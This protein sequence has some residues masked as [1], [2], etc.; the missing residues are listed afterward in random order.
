MQMLSYAN[1]EEI[2][3]ET[4]NQYLGNECRSFKPI[5][6]QGLITDYLGLSL[7]YKKLSKNGTVLGVTTF[8]E[9]NIEV[10]DDDV[11]SFECFPGNT[12]I[13]EKSL[14]N[15][16]MLGRKNFTISHE[17]AHQLLERL[18]PDVNVEICENVKMREYRTLQTNDDWK[19]WQADALASALLMPADLV[20]YAMSVFCGK[21]YIEKL[22]PVV[23]R[24]IFSQFSAMS[25]FLQV[26]KTA[27]A[28]RMKRL[29]LLGV[30][31]FDKTNKFMDVFVGV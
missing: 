9:V 7:E 27:L 15:D 14:K 21:T 24:D 31:D 1:I 25:A 4:L 26:S 10:W 30:F 29:K 20:E 6:I 12:V 22:H 5:N 28:I 23:S 2:A 11:P 8:A 16:K 3:N 17:G 18:F 13:I 19:E